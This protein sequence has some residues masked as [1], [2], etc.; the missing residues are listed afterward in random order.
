ML[1]HE[2]TAML[3]G[4]CLAIGTS[5]VYDELASLSDEDFYCTLHCADKI[6]YLFI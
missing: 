3:Q 2:I 1:L 4:L 5:L 6:I